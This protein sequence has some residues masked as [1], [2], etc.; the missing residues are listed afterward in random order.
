MMGREG[1]ANQRQIGMDIM[2][3]LRAKAVEHSKIARQS[4][5]MSVHFCDTQAILVGFAFK[6]INFPR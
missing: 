4:R 2:S 5:K 1:S 3:S 6:Y